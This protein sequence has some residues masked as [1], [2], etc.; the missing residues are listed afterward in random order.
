[1]C[2]LM[3]W[4]YSGGRHTYEKTHTLKRSNKKMLS[5]KLKQTK[6]HTIKSV[7]TLEYLGLW[8][9]HHTKY[10]NQTS[11]SSSKK[12]K[13]I[14]TEQ[15]QNWHVNIFNNFNWHFDTCVV[16]GCLDVKRKTLLKRQF[17]SIYNKFYYIL[18]SN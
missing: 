18:V 15:W 13:L 9:R 14:Y 6:E 11:N 17:S 5:E 10:V 1:M 3:K 8:M 16:S 4:W 12:T 7:V 2:Q